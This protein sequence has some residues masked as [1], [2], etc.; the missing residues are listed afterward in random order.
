MAYVAWVASPSSQWFNFLPGLLLGGLGMGCTF[1]PLVT[2]AMRNIQ[3]RQ[4]GAASGILN[5]TRQVGGAVGLAVVGAVL[6][7]RL[8]DALHTEAASRSS[9]LPASFRQQ[10]VN[11]FDGVAKSGFQVGRGQTGGAQLPAGISP[12]AAAQLQQLFHDV[13]V[14]AYVDAMRPTIA[15]AITFLFVASVSCWFVVRRRRAVVAAV[16]AGEEQLPAAS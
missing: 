1:A 13:F 6:Q 2:V 14:N 5:T 15:V 7:N 3:P 10:F 4:A 12:Q 16:P 9:A 11:A 8:A